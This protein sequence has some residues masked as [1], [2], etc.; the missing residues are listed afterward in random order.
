MTTCRSSRER[1]RDAYV[2]EISSFVECVRADKQPEVTGND[3]R[4]ALVLALAALRSYREGRPVARQ[5]DRLAIDGRGRRLARWLRRKA[6]I[7]SM[8]RSPS[9][10]PGNS[11]K[12]WGMPS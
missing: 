4:A 11:M 9:S 2:A 12:T 8:E 6:Q 3:G 1:Y 10:M 5:R 7:S